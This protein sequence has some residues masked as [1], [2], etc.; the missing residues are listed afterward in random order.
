MG[1]VVVPPADGQRPRRV[2]WPIV[3]TA[4]V[5]VAVLSLAVVLRNDADQQPQSSVTPVEPTVPT[6]AEPIPLSNLDAPMIVPGTHFFDADGDAATS[7]GA[8][9]NTE[10]T[11]W[12]AASGDYRVEG[13]EPA[14]A[15]GFY[16]EPAQQS[17]DGWVV[18]LMIV[19]VETTPQAGCRSDVWNPAGSSAKDLAEQFANN[20]DVVVRGALAPVTAF[21]YQG[22]HLQVE[23]PEY[24]SVDGYQCAGDRPSLYDG[25]QADGFGRMYSRPGQTLEYWILDVDGRPLLIE[26]SWYAD[27]PEADVADLRT[28]IESLAIIPGGESSAA[29]ERDD[30]RLQS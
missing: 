1:D 27:S 14:L 18:S 4:A 3:A 23:L 28:A 6:P 30:E 7:L 29:V 8:N 22:Y 2:W 16:K 11:G 15:A 20:P 24:S 12:R 26:A 10:G 25:W 17:A 13:S 9:V 21:G 19:Q 5:V